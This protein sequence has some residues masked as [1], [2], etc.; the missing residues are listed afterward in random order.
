MVASAEGRAVAAYLAILEGVGARA[1]EVG[2]RPIASHWPHRGSAYRAGGLF[3]AGQALDGWD[4]PTTPARWWANDAE[5]AEGRER[6]L[7]DT[8]M[9]HADLPEP[10][11]G[12]FRYSNRPGSSFWTLGRDIVSALVPAGPEPWYSRFTWGNVYP[13]G[14]DKRSDLDMRAASP[15]GALKE[16]QDPHVGALLG[17]IVEMLDARRIVIVA[18][19]DY[20]SRAE[21]ALGLTLSAAPF[22]LIRAGHADGRSWVIGYHPNYSR[23]AGKR[24]HGPD[25]GSNAYYVAAV[26]RAFS[27]MG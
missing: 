1:T 14:H 23:K 24:L 8:R 21:Q 19:P 11:S 18:G 4:A 9:W 27:E 26:S 10:L 22:P 25:A 5:S 16:V 20:W 13:L 15:T 3:F 7:A 17:A 12:V 6:I 2:P